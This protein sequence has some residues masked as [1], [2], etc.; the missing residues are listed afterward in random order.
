MKQMLFLLLLPSLFFAQSTTTEENLEK[1]FQNAKKGVYWAL[2][3]IPVKKNSVSNDLIADDKLVASV[4]L[5]KE[6]FGI[7]I[8]S[9]GL[10]E[11][12]EIKVKIFKSTDKLIEEGY[13]RPDTSG[14]KPQAA[15]VKKSLKGRKNR[16]QSN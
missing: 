5:E 3:N 12:T 2:S 8:E 13:L 4:R 15:E 6:I 11:T 7:K 1:A 10:F 16:K 14:T 9:T